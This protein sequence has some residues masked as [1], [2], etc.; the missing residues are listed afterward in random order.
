M[1]LLPVLLLL[2]RLLTLLLLT[3]PFGLLLRPWLNGPQTILMLFVT[4]TEAPEKI[5]IQLKH[6]RR[7]ARTL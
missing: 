1:L 5:C 4:P 6:P 3:L 7:G 2:S